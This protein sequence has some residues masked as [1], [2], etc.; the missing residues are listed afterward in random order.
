M[1]KDK[2]SMENAGRV[3]G[4]VI[5]PNKSKKKTSDMSKQELINELADT[6][7]RSLSGKQLLGGCIGMVGYIIVK[8]V[9]GY[10]W[11]YGDIIGLILLAFLP[12]A[13]F[14]GGMLED[15]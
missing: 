11:H 10:G 14:I 8:A 12:G 15:K 13:V 5:N 6:K 7:N 1:I 2:I 9:T 3:V 4:S